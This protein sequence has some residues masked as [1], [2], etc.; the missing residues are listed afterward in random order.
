[1]FWVV[2]LGFYPNSKEWKA[3]GVAESRTTCGRNV[4]PKFMPISRSSGVHLVFEA[5]PDT[6][7][8]NRENP[9]VCWNA[10]LSCPLMVTNYTNLH[11][12]PISFWML[13][14][15]LNFLGTQEAQFQ[16]ILREFQD[17][18][19]VSYLVLQVHFGFCL[20]HML[21]I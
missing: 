10:T 11:L 3:R 20:V 18:L 5:F 1:M 16:G 2:F 15:S 6:R 4:L 19:V 13:T 12:V 21:L 8:S 9:S 7:P 14:I 17:M